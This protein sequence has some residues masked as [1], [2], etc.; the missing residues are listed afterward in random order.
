MSIFPGSV[1]VTQEA[2]DLLSWVRILAGDPN[3]LWGSSVAEHSPYKRE[4][5]V[6]FLTQDHV[7]R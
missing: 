3:I 4:T 2:L 7:G 1:A 5:Q 6:R